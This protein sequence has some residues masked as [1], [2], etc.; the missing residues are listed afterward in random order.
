MRAFIWLNWMML[1]VACGQ[2]SAAP[3]VVA[4]RQ[5]APEMQERPYVVMVSV[6]GFRHDY[7]ARFEAPALAGLAEVGA[8]AEALL[9]CFPSSTFP[10][11]Y[12]LV[13]G[14]YPARHGLV[15]NTFYD[16]ARQA[17]YQMRDRDKVEDGSWY[18]GTPLWVLAEQQGMLS[19]SFFWVGSEADV[20][21]V[22]PTWSYRYDNA[23]PYAQ[24]VA[25]V[26]NWLEQPAAR[27]PHL[28]FAYF[29][30]TDQV[31]HRHSPEGPAIEAAVAE[32]DSVIGDL[33][34]R[35]AALDLPLYLVLVSDHGMYA[36]DTERPILLERIAELGDFEIAT[37]SCM[38]MLYSA[39]TALVSRTL[40]TLQAQAQGRYTAYR[41]AEVPA[42]LRFSG[43][44]RIGDLVVIAKPPYIFSRWGFPRSPGAHGY[45]PDEVPEM[46][47][48]F[49]IQGPDIRPGLRLPPFRNVHVYPLVAGLL[50]LALPPDLDGDARVLDSLGVGGMLPVWDQNPVLGVR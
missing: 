43:S 26:V 11:H 4:D 27:R 17:M 24:R 1:L 8:V 30:L 20:Q 42:H 7:A 50:G 12:S 15:N 13:T 35:L 28:I 46:G 39:D 10:N 37:G 38:W 16:P 44:D 6:D 19:A 48:I 33:A 2:D 18:G 14:L 36:V 41:R 49:Y 5:N 40:A 45:D 3:R 22:R 47:G 29:S 9:P 25:Q 31:G 21:G 32:M 34:Q 23:V